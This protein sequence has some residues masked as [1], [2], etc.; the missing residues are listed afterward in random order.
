MQT[1]QLTQ[2]FVALVDDADYD[3]V[4][5]YKWHV[6]RNRNNGMY[7]ATTLPR[8]K[9]ESRKKLWMHRFIKGVTDPKVKVDHEDHNGLNNQRENLRK[10]VSGENQGNQRKLRGSS[11]FKGVSWNRNAGKWEAGIGIHGKRV[12][13]GQ[14]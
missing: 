3:R 2:G 10:C 8:V 5:A 9:G 7:A 11:Q 6:K 13:L 4:S 12:Y 14:F 1:I